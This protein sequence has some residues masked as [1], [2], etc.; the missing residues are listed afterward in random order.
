M[1]CFREILVW[2]SAVQW[3]FGVQEAMAQTLSFNV[4]FPRFLIK[5][6]SP[7]TWQETTRACSLVVCMCLLET[8]LCLALSIALH[9]EGL[10]LVLGVFCLARFSVYSVLFCEFI[11]WRA[12]I[13]QWVC[14][15][16]TCFLAKKSA[17]ATVDLLILFVSAKDK[18]V[19]V[20]SIVRS[21]FF[22][23]HNH[24]FLQIQVAHLFEIKK[25][26]LLLLSWITCDPSQEAR[27]YYDA[28]LSSIVVVLVIHALFRLWSQFL[29]SRGCCC[30]G[31]CWCSDQVSIFLSYK[32][33]FVQ[34]WGSPSV[35]ILWDG[36][37]K[38][39]LSLTNGPWSLNNGLWG[40]LSLGAWG[41]GT[42][43][44]RSLRGFSSLKIKERPP[45]RFGPIQRV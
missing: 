30:C 35:Q 8:C 22:N 11:A 19:S 42:F 1:L 32:T 17:N 37:Y 15:V 39:P 18:N 16:C 7:E 24:L 27:N 2:L 40:P 13:C 4:Q 28:T 29:V 14:L 45:S 6:Q 12:T 23:S 21:R 44:V 10:V 41:F 34:N 5:M 25:C 26:C 38:C 3:R 20:H 9:M 31:C 33:L 36:P 43:K